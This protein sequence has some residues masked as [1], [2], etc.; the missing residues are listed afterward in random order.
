MAWHDEPWDNGQD[1]LAGTPE[2]NKILFGNYRETDDHAVELFARS[3]FYDDQSAYRELIDYMWDEYG[4]NF[5]DAFV[6]EDFRK[7]YEEHYGRDG[8]KR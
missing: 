3:M 2:L 4:I 7:W 5:E 8:Y 6:W 1:F